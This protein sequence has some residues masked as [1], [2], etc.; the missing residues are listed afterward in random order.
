MWELS[1]LPSYREFSVRRILT[2]AL[3]A[4][5]AAFLWTILF[6]PTSHA[7]DATWKGTVIQYNGND[8][9]GPASA[10]TIT[11]LGLADGT[12]AYTYVEPAAVSAGTAATPDR[13]IHIIYFEPTI[14][15]SVATSAK[16]KTYIYQ[17]PSSFTGPSSPIDIAVTQQTTAAANPGTSSC[18]IGSGID[19]LICGPTKWLAK[20]MDSIFAIL[21]GFLAV[22]PVGTG[23]E[24]ALFRAWTYM[25][26]FA[27]VAF[28]IA[29]LVIIYSQLTNAGITNY[30]IK[31]LLPR[32]IVAALLVNLSYYICAVAVDISNVLGYSIQDV[33]IQLRNSLVGTE[34]NSWNLINFESVTGFILSGGTAITAGAIG[35]ITTVSFYGLSGSV[36]L[37]LPAL[38]TG[39]VAVLTALIVMAARQA[40]VT[41][42][43]IIAPLAFVAYLLPNTDKWFDKW[44]STFMTML[45]L[46]PAFSVVFG[47]SQL[48]AA[49]IIQNADSINLVILALVVQVTPLLITPLLIKLSGSLLG[50][51]A[52]MVNNPNKGIID[53]TRNWSKDRADNIKATR[54]ANKDPSRKR[55]FMLRNGQKLDR[56]RREREGY[57]KDNEAIAENL[58]NDTEAGQKLYNAQHATETDKKTIEERL[59]RDLS[60]KIQVTPELLNKEMTMRVMA[61]DSSLQ[62]AKLDKIHEE[63]RAGVRP[64]AV[65]NSNGEWVGGALQELTNKSE[66]VTRDLALTSIAN[67]A[68]KRVQNNNLSDALL[69]NTGT[70]NGKSLQD[71]AG[72]VD[73]EG[74][75]AAVAFAV[76]QRHKAEVDLVNDRTQIITQFELNG[77]ER[78]ALAEGGVV[79]G[80]IKDK[81]GNVKY[82]YTFDG[83]DEYMQSAAIDRQLDTGS[84]ENILD[85]IRGSGAS[86]KVH[87]KDISDAIP[88]KGLPNKASFLAGVFIDKVL[89]GEIKDEASMFDGIVNTY[90]MGGKFKAEQLAQN[91][92]FAIDMMFD[93]I[94]S[95]PASQRTP[96]MVANFAELKKTIDT[97]L[98]EPE[99]SK[100]TTLGSRRAFDKLKTAL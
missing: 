91:D 1:S 50:K 27:N 58:F 6:A 90:I 7:A 19:W 54:M 59:S 21:T 69:K 93:A 75:K 46:F 95:V 20:G 31:K 8:Y 13:K 44:R 24:T 99:L 51:V 88:K 53:R 34:G 3:T 38:V 98:T 68:A 16:Y 23:Q 80:K 14:D 84:M 25:R 82:E 45:V 9:S 71:Y 60:V 35:L 78:Q 41:I 10:K 12:T 37:L 36:F 43:I 62:K 32:L 49:A 72:G 81:Q 83:S 63:M 67:Q 39:L 70:V 52:G 47:G 64:G 77:Q 85:I 57:R 76:N 56:K 26:S 92:A 100:S 89:R 40:I 61:D 55:D 65:R 22:R 30:S 96:Q 74:A 17:G 66:T 15:S 97:I 5:F 87:K 48:A 42:L 73:A 29:F 18:D 86:L 79:L 94:N 4:L 33:F 11:D 2:Y 28:V